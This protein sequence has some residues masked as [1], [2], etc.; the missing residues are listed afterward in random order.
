MDSVCIREAGLYEGKENGEPRVQDLKA[1]GSGMCSGK[2]VVL[3]FYMP[4][5]RKREVGERL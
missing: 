1:K 5:G 4:W 2:G 3:C